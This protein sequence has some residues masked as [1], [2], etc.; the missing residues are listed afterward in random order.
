MRRLML[1][2]TLFVLTAGPSFAAGSADGVWLTQKQDAKVRVAPCRD[3]A[4]Q[5]CGEIVWVRA[6]S[7]AGGPPKTD[8]HNPDAKLR[9]RPLIGL[10]VIRDFHVA[11]AGRW[12]G[13]KIYDP[14]T[15]KT[16]ASKMRL[17]ADGTLKVDGCVM[18]FCQSQT[19]TRAD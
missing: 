4:D 13:G 16:Y 19:W 9:D 12:E 5:L 18:M 6:P 15:G 7:G 14:H 17:A 8:E 2:V 11:E 1:A 10:R 3:H